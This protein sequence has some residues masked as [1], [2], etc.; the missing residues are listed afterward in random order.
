VNDDLVLSFG[1][2]DDITIQYDANGNSDLQITGVVGFDGAVDMASTLGVAGVSTLAGNVDATAGLDVTTAA[3]TAAAG[4]TNS[5]GEVLVSGGNMQINDDLILTFGTNDD[6]SLT[7]DEDG[8]DDLQIT[9]AV[10][11]DGAVDMAS[12]LGVTG[13]STLAG[14]V[15][16][17]AGLDVSGGALTVANQAIT[18]T[19]GG[20]VT[21]AGNVDAAAGLD[22]TTAALTSA[23][24][25]THSGGELLVSGGNMQINDDL[26]LTFGT[27]NDVSL[28]YD[29]DGNNDL[30][31]IGAVGFDG[32]VDMASTLTVAGVSTL[33]GNLD[34]VANTA[35]IQDIDADSAGDVA[36]AIDA[37]GTG[38]VTIGGASTGNVIIGGGSDLILFGASANATL[39]SNGA[40]D[41]VL[42]TNSGTNSGTITITDAANGDITIAPNGTG[43]VVLGAEAVFTPGSQNLAGDAALTPTSTVM[44]V[45]SDTGPFDVTDITAGA[46][47]QLLII[48]NADGV[49]TIDI[50][51]QNNITSAGAF[52]SA[53]Y[54]TMMFVYESTA[55]QWIELARSNN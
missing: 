48:I 3:L 47:G 20:Q 27:D 18:Q 8:N 40:Y 17:T 4:I 9:G 7:Y 45:T 39:S 52:A 29:E 19:T 30:Q 44:E 12:T 2:G 55:T 11:F 51:E 54:D 15:D 14:N 53:Q 26:V 34:L 42:E 28:N 24:G 21:F 6:V 22:V 16:A 31:I 23:A 38:T 50:L 43:D 1:T 36:L 35:Y 25:T 32:A 5:G 41:L 49:D 10:G 46:D 33:N 13:V 37:A